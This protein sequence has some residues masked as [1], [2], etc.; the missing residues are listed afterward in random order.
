MDVLSYTQ[1]PTLNRPILLLSFT[2]WNDAGTA[3]TFATKF[4]LQRLAGRKF[5]DIDPETFYNF[6]E[7]RPTV[8]MK[9]GER[10]IS[11]PKNEFSYAKDSG[12]V[13]DI[14]LGLGVEPHLRWRSYMDA[15]MR[16]VKE[17][18]VELVVTL[19]ALLADVAYS[20]PVPITGV[21]SDPVLARRLKLGVSQYEGPTGI[22]GVLHDM[23]RQQGV[24]AIMIWANVPHYI[25]ATP[26]V[27]AALAIVQR[28]LTLLD[29]STDLSDLERASV[30]FDKR[31]ADVLASDPSVADYVR[32]LE[33]RDDAETA[34]GEQVDEI[35]GLPSGEELAR[36]LEQF[37]R[38]QRRGSDE[39]H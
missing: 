13:Q 5:A 38:E 24:P 20:R 31:V 34:D 30:E 37:L 32:R 3:A 27:K 26:N 29:Y 9:N 23:C 35:D 18:N 4:L 15:V 2:G 16:V 7:R 33:E 21:A 19:G 25:A 11:W 17:C 28:V 36:E 8:R 1:I 39:D 14:I 10:I 12:L 6:V 22:V